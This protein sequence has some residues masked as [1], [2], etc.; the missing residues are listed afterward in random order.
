[1]SIKLIEKALKELA[2]KRPIFWSEADFQFSFAWHLKE[3][4]GDSV[5]I[6]LERRFKFPG[7]DSDKYYVDIWVEY[8]GKVYPIELKYK[9]KKCNSSGITTINQ[10]ANDL[11]RYFYLWDIHRLEQLKKAVP[12]FAEG[13]AIMLTND[14]NYYN[15]PVGKR[16]KVA[17]DHKFRIHKRPADD[18]SFPISSVIQWDISHLPDSKIGESWTLKYPGFTLEEPFSVDWE[19]YRKLD[20]CNIEL[21]YLINVVKSL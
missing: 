14:C 1:M 9:T 2:N 17:V 11:G 3:I 6:E 15:E 21:K 8:D 4:L 5:K 18:V 20:D 7:E 13:Y 12:N 10:S 16:P 19:S